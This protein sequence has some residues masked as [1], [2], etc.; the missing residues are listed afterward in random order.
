LLQNV[1]TYIDF[2]RFVSSESGDGS[3]PI[4]EPSKREFIAIDDSGQALPS[5]NGREMMEEVML[6]YSKETARFQLQA[7]R[8]FA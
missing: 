5:R 1:A 6:K 2:A 3:L 4:N 8:N 7:G